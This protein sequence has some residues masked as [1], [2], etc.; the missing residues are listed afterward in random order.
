MIFRLL[1][2]HFSMALLGLGLAASAQAG[3]ITVVAEASDGPV[4]ASS[5]ASILWH[6]LYEHEGH[7]AVFLPSLDESAVESMVGT[8]RTTLLH[9]QLTW[10]ADAYR[11][12]RQGEGPHMLGGSYPSVVTT[13][14][15]LQGTQLVAT[16]TWTTEGPLTVYEVRAPTPERFIGMPE[17][18][19]QET[20]ALA[21]RPVAAPVWSIE[22]DLRSIPIVLVADEEYRSF[23]GEKRWHSVAGR[24]IA[25]ANALLRPAGIT[26][27]IVETQ[28]WTSPDHLSDLSDLLRDLYQQ[29]R[30][31]AQALRV[32]FTGQTRLEAAMHFEMEDVG[33][34]FTPGRDVLVADQASPPGHDPSWD[35]AEEG[36]AVAHEVLHALGIPHT[37]QPGMLMSSTKR[38]TVHRMSSSTIELA[39]TAA[40]ARYAHWDTLAALTSLTH[41]AEQHLED[42]E[43]KLDFISDNLAFGPGVIEPGALEPKELSALTNVAIGRYYLRQTNENPDQARELRRHAQHHTQSA[44]AQEPSL[45]SLHAIQRQVLAA[46]PSDSLSTNALSEDDNPAGTPPFDDLPVCLEDEELL[47]CE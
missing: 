3:T 26:L 23:Y 8:N 22:P 2:L 43:Y 33:R 5:F 46:L 44:L 12:E 45:R 39:R 15:V 16:R 38:G 25:R 32:G 31:H 47:T 20:V 24:A 40:E 9:A 37:D 36:V 6:A 34:A 11:L 29:P 21:V 27:D 10:K 1:A 18:S 14:Y 7:D 41:A 30:V 35:V 42:L 17:V 28:T 19:L 4:P 13:E